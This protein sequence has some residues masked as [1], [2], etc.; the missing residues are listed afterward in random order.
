MANN[1]DDDI[2]T[3]K[4]NEIRLASHK[5]KAFKKDYKKCKGDE[6]KAGYFN[7]I[8]AS[9]KEQAELY[10]AL[11]EMAEM[12]DDEEMEELLEMLKGLPVIKYCLEMY[13]DLSILFKR[14]FALFLENMR[15]ATEEARNKEAVRKHNKNEEKFYIAEDGSYVRTVLW[16]KR[17]VQLALQKEKEELKN[18]E[19]KQ[20]L[21]KKISLQFLLDTATA[22]VEQLVELILVGA[23]MTQV[24]H[25]LAEWVLM[26]TLDL[27][28]VNKNSKKFYTKLIDL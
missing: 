23:L 19:K 12:E 9:P 5:A 22:R 8:C 14:A 2:M 1:N 25:F 18:L 10:W 7:S 4:P 13:Q 6:M 28:W 27:E 20:H 17:L 24:I 16:T 26:T 3:L 15:I 11:E 21:S